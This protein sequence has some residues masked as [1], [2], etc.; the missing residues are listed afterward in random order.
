MKAVLPDEPEAQPPR[1]NTSLC[2]HRACPHSPYSRAADQLP[3]PPFCRH[4]PAAA[5]YVPE[6]AVKAKLAVPVKSMVL[7]VCVSWRVKVLPLKVP[8]MDAEPPQAAASP[9]KL[10][11]PV[12]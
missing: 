4:D 1:K 7:S 9:V 8:D 5:V 10:T 2:E 6:A 11:V 12:I 3:N